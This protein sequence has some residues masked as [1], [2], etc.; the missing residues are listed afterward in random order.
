R[1]TSPCACERPRVGED[2]RRLSAVVVTARTRRNRTRA[3]SGIAKLLDKAKRISPVRS[4]VIEDVRAASY[5]PRA[6]RKTQASSRARVAEFGLARL[7]GFVI[8][9]FRTTQS[10]GNA[11][12]PLTYAFSRR[13]PTP[14]RYLTPPVSKA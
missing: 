8:A 14:L 12:R 6:G 11:K 13:R 5:R 10:N 9:A 7:P 1:K 2:R 3:S 4:L